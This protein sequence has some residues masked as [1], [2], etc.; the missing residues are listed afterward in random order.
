MVLAIKKLAWSPCLIL[1]DHTG[2]GLVPM[3]YPI[4]TAIKT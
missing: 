1:R 3:A 2:I 4:A